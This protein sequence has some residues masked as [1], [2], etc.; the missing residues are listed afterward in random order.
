M[1]RA[2]H[3]GIVEAPFERGDAKAILSGVFHMNAH[4]ADIA[5]DVRVIRLLLDDDDEEAE[6]DDEDDRDPEP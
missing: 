3:D 6:E 5:R 2:V 4:L 1:R